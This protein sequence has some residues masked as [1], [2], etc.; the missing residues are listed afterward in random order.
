MDTH[1]FSPIC[2]T[3]RKTMALSSHTLAIK[4]LDLICDM[5]KYDSGEKAF[6][7]IQVHF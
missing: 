1:E 4:H 3:C 7:T 5:R 6:I 2:S